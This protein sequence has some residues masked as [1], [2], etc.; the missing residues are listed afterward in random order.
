MRRNRNFAIQQMPPEFSIEPTKMYFSE[1]P[2][3]IVFEDEISQSGTSFM[4]PKLQRLMD[5]VRW[6]TGRTP[7]DNVRQ[8][9]QGV[10]TR[11]TQM[12]RHAQTPMTV[13][14]KLQR[15]QNVNTRIDEPTKRPTIKGRTPQQIARGAKS[16]ARQIPARQPSQ[17]KIDR[18][19]RRRSSS[20]RPEA[21]ATYAKELQQATPQT[22]DAIYSRLEKADRQREQIVH[23]VGAKSLTE[24]QL[25]SLPA[26]YVRELQK[27][28]DRRLNS[29]PKQRVMF[30]PRESRGMS[31][32]GQY[33]SIP[34]PG[35]VEAAPGKY[36]RPEQVGLA[37]RQSIGRLGNNA[38]PIAETGVKDML[39]LGGTLLAGVIGLMMMR[40]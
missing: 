32:H 30:D 13:I 23:K 25:R 14:R 1:P 4:S 17:Q 31:S 38:Q 40:G 22:V 11:L 35:L 27:R 39:L 16:M 21:M 8:S 3:K 26:G 9:D 12:H 7:M 29:Q 5:P 36:V 20:L 19:L 37:P 33:S 18:I 10:I 24:S 15:P 28:A 2:R 6:Q 34:R